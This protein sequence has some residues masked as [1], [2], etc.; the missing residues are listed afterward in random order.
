MSFIK[1][2]CQLFTFL[3]LTTYSFAHIC[4]P[5]ISPEQA[6]L[7]IKHNN[8]ANRTTNDTPNL[9]IKTNPTTTQ[10]T[11]TYPQSLPNFPNRINLNTA[12][13][14]EL[15]QLNGIG[16]SKAQNIILYRENFGKFDSVDDLAKVK[17]IGKATVEKN[18][19]LISVSP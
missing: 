14:A 1:K 7:A 15:T 3:L 19:H 6:F 18:R 13:E 8:I 4:T 11:V 17:G 12:S 5:T 2:I 16:A 9:D 10:N